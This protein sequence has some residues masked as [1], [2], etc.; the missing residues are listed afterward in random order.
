VLLLFGYHDAD[1]DPRMPRGLAHA[2]ANHLETGVSIR[3]SGTARM[4]A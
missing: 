4:L 1:L 3:G 2:G